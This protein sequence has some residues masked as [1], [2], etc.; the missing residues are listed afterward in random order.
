MNWRLSAAVAVALAACT[1]YTGSQEPLEGDL[2]GRCFPNGTCN[3]GL[4]CVGGKCALD[5][6]FPDSSAAEDAGPL[7]ELDA[8]TDGNPSNDASDASDASKPLPC[9]VIA[10]SAPPG[11]VECVDSSCINYGKCCGTNHQC[12]QSCTNVQ[13]NMPCDGAEDCSGATKRCCGTLGTKDI[14]TSA[15]PRGGSFSKLV[16][17]CASACAGEEVELCTG[18]TCGAGQRCTRLIATLGVGG[19]SNFSIG[20]C[21]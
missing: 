7:P 14:D 1:T 18:N 2:D 21:E 3:V 10:S 8:G 5:P 16:T 19:G 4:V 6:S 9:D 20:Y 11:V 17:R 13:V 15:C 12:T